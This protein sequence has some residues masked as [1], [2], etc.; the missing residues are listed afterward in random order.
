[1]TFKEV[2]FQDVLDV[3]WGDTKTTKASYVPNGYVAYSASGPDGFLERF[4]YDREGIVLSAIGANCGTTF[5]ATGKW[6]CIKNTI[7]I[8]SK[9]DSIDLKYV[10]Y[11]TKLQ[12]FWPIRGSAQSFISQT[13][14]RE[15]VIQLPELGVQKFIGNFLYEL[16]QKIAVNLG[17][18][19]TL[20]EIAEALF[21]SWLIDFE[22]VKTKMAGEKPLGIDSDTSSLFPESM[23]DSELGLI[24]KG[25]TVH[26]LD[27]ISDYLNGLAMQKYPFVDGL[28]ALPVIKIAQLRAGNTKGADIASGLLDPRYVIKDGDI[29]FSWSGTLEVEIWAGGPGALNQHLFKVTGATVPDWFSFLSTRHHLSMFREVAT[30]KATTMGHIQRGHLS[31]AKIAVPPK[32]LLE[33]MGEVFE[34]LVTLRIAHLVSNRTLLEL[35]DS[36]LPRLVSGVFEIPKEMLA[37]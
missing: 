26:G 30:S 37:S 21:K 36:L 11:M 8:F 5:F 2:Q 17:I 20:E 3:Q 24:P 23:D 25:W 4:D 31:E 15:L 33:T 9:S 29:L 16:E 22:P 14:I 35:R 32:K 10:Y 7:R 27:E 19:S 28:T 12:D 13:D 6:S 18:S 34:P 1:M